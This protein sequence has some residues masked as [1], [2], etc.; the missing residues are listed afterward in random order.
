ML[1]P[2]EQPVTPA[3]PQAKRSDPGRNAYGHG[4]NSE[5]H[6]LAAF[7]YASVPFD[8]LFYNASFQPV[9]EIPRAAKYEE[10]FQSQKSG[11]AAG[12]AQIS[13]TSFCA[14][15]III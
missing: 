14:A 11:Q 12:V 2:L 4:G 6:C 7:I 9:P 13:T 10:Q 3:V 15:T 1:M 5:S 8:P